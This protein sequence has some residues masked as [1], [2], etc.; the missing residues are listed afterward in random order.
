MQ[1][2]KLTLE[3]FGSSTFLKEYVRGSDSLADYYSFYPLSN[4]RI[5]DLYKD[6]IRSIEGSFKNERLGI[7]SALQSFHATLGIDE[8]QREIR[9]KL[10]RDDCFCVVTGQ[11]L[12][13]YGGPLYTFFK[14][15]STI[16]KAREISKF[17]GKTIIPV[18]WLADE[19]HDYD[20]INTS[21]WYEWKSQI[22]HQATDRQPI[23]HRISSNSLACS[24]EHEERQLE[25][26]KGKPVSSSS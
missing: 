6:R 4:N 7:V 13:W 18:F 9:E 19:D 2:Q 23:C 3:Q 26:E 17:T 12:A 11:Q 14:V 20:E 16:L 8:E 10:L 5:G 1:I 21:T 24:N 22:N 25:D 15:I